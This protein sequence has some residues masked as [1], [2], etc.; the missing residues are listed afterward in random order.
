MLSSK[1][2]HFSQFFL[3]VFSGYYIT[4]LPLSP[5]YF[6]TII[7]IST[8]FLRFIKKRA[9]YND[10]IINFTLFV[11]FINLIPQLFLQPNISTI[12]SF[13][14]SMIVFLFSY[15]S[16]NMSN[17]EKIIKY[18]TTM[19][20]CSIPLLI[21]EAYYRITNP[22]FFVDFAE[23]GREE[24]FFYYYKVN[25]IMY[26][27]SNFV[28][29]YIL[30]LIY[31]LMYLTTHAKR[32]H[33]VAFLCLI[34]LLILTLSRSSILSMLIFVI[35][36]VF[37]KYI[38][39]YRIFVFPLIMFMVMILIPIA[40][41]YSTMDDSFSTKFFLF[42]QTFKYLSSASLSEVIFGVGFGN[43]YTVL[44]LGAHNFFLTYLVESGVLGLVSILLLWFYF[45]IRSKYKIGIVM[46][47]FLFN[48]LSVSTVAIPYLYA[49]FAVVLVLERKR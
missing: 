17:K 29:L 45:L 22:I 14:F 12:V 33:I 8:F 19:I 35:P 2:I 47:P 20:Y 31:F 4:K 30:S 39:K 49:I 34:I 37:R 43:A 1:L 25:S 16:L 5:I 10:Q 3:V 28:A 41:K 44:S 46:F 48:G 9:V 7:G 21:Y 40:I 42:S 32:K 23:K 24:L 36:F 13:V 18:S 6:F 15:L 27:D 38:H 26:M 11:L